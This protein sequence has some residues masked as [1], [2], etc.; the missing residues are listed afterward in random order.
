[1]LHLLQ[2]NCFACEIFEVVHNDLFAIRYEHGNPIVLR[3]L[4]QASL[5]LL[6]FHFNLLEAAEVNFVEDL[7]LDFLEVFFLEPDLLRNGLHFFVEVF[8]LLF[9]YWDVLDLVP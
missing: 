9:V 5:G 3:V 1:M 8:N 2:L 7:V 6:D 4:F